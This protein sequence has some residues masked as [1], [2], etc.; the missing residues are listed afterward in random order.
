MPR[1]V[2]FLRA[3]NVGGHTVTMARLRELFEDLGFKDVATFIASGNVLFSSPGKSTPALERKIESHLEKSL[4]YEVKTFLRTDSEVVAIS[5][6]E[7]FPPAKVRSAGAFCVG[8]MSQPLDATAKRA[9]DG[10]T[11]AIDQ[12]HTHGREVYWLCEKRQHESKFSNV[13]FE[14]T[15]KTRITFRGVNTIVKLAAI[16]QG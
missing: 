6:Y 16:T 1:Y 11:S 12:F 13:V 15:T 3:I 14:K 9:L 10:L 4:G 8:F 7:A 2:A 5:E